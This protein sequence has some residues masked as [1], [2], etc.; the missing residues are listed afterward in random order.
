MFGGGD[1]ESSKNPETIL[2]E[3][4]HSDLWLMAS[5]ISFTFI[6]LK[7]HKEPSPKTRQKVLK[8]AIS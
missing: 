1:V 8:V 2:I 5:Y 6:N 4:V 7:L 3:N